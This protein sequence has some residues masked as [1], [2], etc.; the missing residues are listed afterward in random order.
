MVDILRNSGKIPFE[1]EL[2]KILVNGVEIDSEMDWINWFGMLFGPTLLLVSNLEIIVWIPNQTNFLTVISWHLKEQ[3]VVELCC[4]YFRYTAYRKEHSM[5]YPIL[6]L[7]I[8]TN[9]KWK[10]SFYFVSLNE[11]IRHKREIYIHAELKSEREMLIPSKE[12][13]TNMPLV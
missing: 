8:K 5:M 4:S 6:K 12:K 3:H 9:K 1:K 2:L 10:L 13:S 11:I 7:S